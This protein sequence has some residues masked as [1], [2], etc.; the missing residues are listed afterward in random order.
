MKIQ[1]LETYNERLDT[2]LINLGIKRRKIHPFIKALPDFIQNLMLRIECGTTLEKSLSTL[3]EDYRANE[4]YADLYQNFIKKKSALLTFNEFCKDENHPY[5]WRLLILINQY[6]ITGSKETLIS[7]ENLYHEIWR[8]RHTEIKAKSER[9]S[10]I[11][12]FLLMF[13]FISVIT[14]IISPIFLTMSFQ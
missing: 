7:M 3:I 9:I 4:A 8:M 1:I 14:V 11:L 5:L 10:V 12:T 13:S 6:H 2:Y